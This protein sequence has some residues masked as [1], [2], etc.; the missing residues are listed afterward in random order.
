MSKKIISFILSL[1]LIFCLFSS[2]SSVLAADSLSKAGAVTTASSVL[3]VR[4]RASSDSAI[5][6]T[7][8]KGSYITLLSKS[9]S[10]WKVEYAKE[11][12]GYCHTNYIT[13][14][15]GTPKTVNTS[16]GN[17]NI[18]SGAGTYYA[19]IG[20]LSKGEN[21]IALYAVDDWTRILY[22]GTKTGY[23]S[24]AYLKSASSSGGYSVISLNVPSFKQTDPR[25]RDTY[26]GSSG[27]TIAQIG[28]ATTAIAMMESYRTGSTV[29]PDTMA[30]RLNYTSSGS[31]YWP[32]NYTAV[33]NSSG[34]LKNIYQKLSQGKPVL[35][36][37]KNSRGGQHWVVIT[38]FSG[39]NLSAENFT[40]NDP[41]SNSRTNLQSFLNL[42]PTF[43]KYFYY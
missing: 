11:Q 42:Y 33:I 5:V 41:G 20:I 36:G 3:N 17:L 9:G 37:A 30:K 43:Y 35:F 22:N 2:F 7:L 12:Y 23:V 14:V 25:W 4:Q 28:C 40:I 31:V 39:G 6:Y 32:S 34:Y 1:I 38:G 27:K 18:R 29:Y 8:R 24:T 19:R 21:V 10:W 26:I 15:E 13:V 16:Y